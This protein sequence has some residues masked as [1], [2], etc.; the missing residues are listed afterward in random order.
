MNSAQ[1]CIVTALKTLPPYILIWIHGVVSQ[2]F[3]MRQSHIT[4]QVP[5]SGNSDVGAGSSIEGKRHLPSVIND[6]PLRKNCDTAESVVIACGGI[7]FPA[8]HL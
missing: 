5:K 6:S 1:F 4:E 3:I 8:L 7:G 2:I